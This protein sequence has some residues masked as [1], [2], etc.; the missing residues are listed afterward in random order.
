MANIRGMAASGVLAAAGPFDDPAPVGIVGI[1]ILKAECLK[2][3]GKLSA[4]GSSGD[5][6][7]PIFRAM[8]LTDASALMATPLL[9][10]GRN[11][12]DPGRASAAGFEW[13]GVGRP[14][15]LP[16]LRDEL[17][18]TEPLATVSS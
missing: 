16:Q 3:A 5:R 13:V 9:I 7:S 11:L 15:H 18:A 12:L 14:T 4:A 1:F 6:E 8:P 17:L 2:A 10:D